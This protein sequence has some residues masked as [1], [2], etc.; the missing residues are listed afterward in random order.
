MSSQS[1]ILMMPN[2]EIRHSVPVFKLNWFVCPT[3]EQPRF[4]HSVPSYFS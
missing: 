3:I 4:I 2:G 1:D